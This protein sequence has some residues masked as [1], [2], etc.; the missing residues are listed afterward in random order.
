MKRISEV[1]CQQ[2]VKGGADDDFQTV[3]VDVYCGSGYQRKTKVAKDYSKHLGEENVRGFHF[4]ETDKLDKGLAAVYV[5][6]YETDKSVLQSITKEYY[7]NGELD[8]S[9]RIW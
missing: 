3:L 5:I 2:H 9:Y 8:K 4:S 6:I 1:H 7:K